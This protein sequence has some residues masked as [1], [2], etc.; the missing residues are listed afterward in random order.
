[1]NVTTD[2]VHLAAFGR[3]LKAAREAKGW[4]QTYVAQYIGTS[5]TALRWWEQG[6]REPGASFLAKLA[7]LF[8]STMDAL[9]HG[10]RR[11]P[12]LH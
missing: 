7:A 10:E 6:E 9:W 11:T 2:R 3:R 8:G 1:M 5:P 4:T 12:V